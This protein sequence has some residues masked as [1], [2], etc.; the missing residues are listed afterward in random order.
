ME[1]QRKQRGA[2]MLWVLSSLLT[3]G[4]IGGAFVNLGLY[5]HRFSTRNQAGTEAFYLSESSI[6]QALQ[7]LRTQASPPSGTVPMVLFGGWQNLGGGSYLVTVDPD[8]NNPTS[9]LK[10]YSIEGWGASGSQ[11][12]PAAVRQTTLVVQTESFARYAYFTDNEKS[13]SGSTVWFIT[14]DHIEGPTHTNGQFSIYGSPIFDGLVS[15]VAST[16]RFFNPPPVG[17]NNPVF[18]GGLE[19]GV[20]PKPFLTTFPPSL[21]NAATSGGTVFNGDT[22]VTLLSDGTMQVTTKMIPD[23][24]LPLPANGVLYVNN[25]TVTLQGTLKGQLTIGT[26]KDVKIVNSVTYS[27][28]PEVNP[29]SR[30]LLGIVAGG[31]VIIASSAPNN[32][33]VDASIMALNTSFTV[34]NY[35]SGLKGTLTVNGGIVQAKRGPVGTFNS[36]TGQKASGYTKDYH[37]DERL[38]SMIPPFF[39]VTGDY[40]SLVWQGER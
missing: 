29:Y 28:D 16:L 32:L 9:F 38:L 14:A 23:Q 5:E 18:N 7:W 30:D 2:A 27:D 25:G 13:P 4:V 19:L 39:P 21:V 40:V 1:K 35:W 8:D 37:Y 31:N 34:Q 10:R 6:D 20:P 36:R 22:T 3:V 12:A 33:E 26:N 17:G 15:S 11:A 24:V